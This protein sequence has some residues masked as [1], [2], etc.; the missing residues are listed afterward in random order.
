MGAQ[1]W[2]DISA[3]V[4]FIFALVAQMSFVSPGREPGPGSHDP[5]MWPEPDPTSTMEQQV[6]YSIG[7]PRKETKGSEDLSAR[8]GP[9]SYHPKISS[10]RNNLVFRQTDPGTSGYGFGRSRR[11]LSE[12]HSARVRGPPGPAMEQSDNRKYRQAP[13]Y[14][15][16]SEEK[17]FRSP[18]IWDDLPGRGLRQPGPGEHCPDDTSTSKF[19]EVSSPSYSIAPAPSSVSK[20]APKAAPGPGAY[21]LKDGDE[22]TSKHAAPP[23]CKFGTSPRTNASHPVDKK[24]TIGPADTHRLVLPE[25]VTPF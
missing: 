22:H 8:V 20:V 10:F 23:R 24:T 25:R 12:P 17:F 6:S 11:V 14:S 5:P 16:G 19:A 13:Q 1:V 15:F 3:G 4:L 2:L 7:S 18:G 9:G 21:V